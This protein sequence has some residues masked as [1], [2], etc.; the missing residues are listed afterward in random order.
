MGD[1]L[2]FRRET[3]PSPRS[4][5]PLLGVLLLA[6]LLALAAG[7]LL[8]LMAGPSPPT[9]IEVIGDVP[10]PG[11]YEVPGGEAH[12][13]LALAG[14][15]LRPPGL[16]VVPEGYV[17]RVDGDRVSL[18]PM[19]E[20]LLVGLPIDVNGA[21]VHELMAVPGIGAGTAGAIVTER[22]ER[23]PFASVDDLERVRGIGPATLERLRPFVT[24]APPPQD[25]P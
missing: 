24:V 21:E 20:P 9:L 17:L 15:P 14:S 12:D 22:A 3:R 4:A 11:L 5:G 13:A 23:G 18:E 1:G 16:G 7:P 10:A 2:S 25:A 6:G 8:R 19:A